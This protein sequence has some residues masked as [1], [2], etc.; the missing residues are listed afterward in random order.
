[1]KDTPKRY[2]FSAKRYG[3]GWTPTAHEGWLV[4]I[5]YIGGIVFL[6]TYV[7]KAAPFS[8]VLREFLI[9]TGVLTALLFTI[10]WKTGERPRRQWG[11]ADKRR[12]ND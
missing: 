10:C 9:P 11:A 3:W 2:W 5:L 12:K 4:V 8:D 7:A 6:A 1:M